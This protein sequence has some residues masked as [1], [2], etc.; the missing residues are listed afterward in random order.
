VFRHE[1]KEMVITDHFRQHL[2]TS[3]IR[4]AT[5]QWPSLGYQQHD[6]SSLEAS[7]TQ[8]EIKNT[9]F[10]MPSDKAPGPDGFTGIFFKEC[11]EIIK[12]D[13]TA[14]FN[15]LHNLNAQHLNLL[16]S[17]NIWM[18]SMWGTIDPLA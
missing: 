14:A 13:L 4:P 9:I 8:E 6:L 18:Q 16:N 7:F 2:G 5:F 12:F 3:A 15:Q 10:S 17:V 11:W 1:D